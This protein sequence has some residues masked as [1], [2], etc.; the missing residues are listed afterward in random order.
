LNVSS[1]INIVDL[2]PTMAPE[3]R[4]D[5]RRDIITEFTKITPIINRQIK[6]KILFINIVNGQ[7]LTT[8]TN[9]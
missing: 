6:T 4:K 8:S 2:M 7:R 1:W 3:I 5:T 9:T